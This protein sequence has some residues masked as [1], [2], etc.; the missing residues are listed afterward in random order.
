M[1][2]R[3]TP[4]PLPPPRC[5]GGPP[6]TW[7]DVRTFRREKGIV[8]SYKRIDTCAAEFKADTPY[9]Y[10]CYDGACESNP[11]PTR[12]VRLRLGLWVWGVG[13][14]VRVVCLEGGLAHATLPWPRPV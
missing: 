13:C 12:K 6:V 1:E 5:A 3:T 8:P 7:Q 2:C 9:M 11:V 10:S 4:P 14:W